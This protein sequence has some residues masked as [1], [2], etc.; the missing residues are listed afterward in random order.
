MSYVRSRTGISA[1][2][3]IFTPHRYSRACSRGRDP[4][5][6]AVSRN[7]IATT[8]VSALTR[9]PIACDVAMT[10]E[11]RCGKSTAYR[12]HERE[13]SGSP[14]H[15]MRTVILPKDNEKRLAEIPAGNPGSPV[16]P[17]VEKYGR[18]P[19]NRARNG[20]WNPCRTMAVPEV[21]ASFEQKLKVI[22][23]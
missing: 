17:F 4:E 10:G 16:P 2:R 20:P 18:G 6:R 1:C 19:A 3:A 12:R 7:T 14:P 21:A 13:T 11:S 23:N 8:I 5:R 9:T 15:G 22:K